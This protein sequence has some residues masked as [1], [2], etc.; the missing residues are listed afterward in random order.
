MSRSASKWLELWVKLKKKNFQTVRANVYAGR[1]R[2]CGPHK[3]C[4]AERAGS[5]CA[6]LMRG[7]PKRGGP[8]RIATPT[9]NKITKGKLGFSQK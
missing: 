5:R 8:A 2:L 3:M 6:S 1:A 9:Y 4:G 7:G